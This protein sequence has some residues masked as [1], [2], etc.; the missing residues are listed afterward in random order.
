V[1]KLCLPVLL[2]SGSARPLISFGHFQQL[3]FLD[4]NI[5][6]LKTDM[7]CVTASGQSLEIVG[8]VKVVLKIHGFSWSWVFLVSRRLRDQPILRADFISA[9]KMVL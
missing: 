2:D 9:N 8:Q 6:L 1:G 4:P 3:S 7:T 5:Q